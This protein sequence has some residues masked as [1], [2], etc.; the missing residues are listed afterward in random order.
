MSLRSRQEHYRV[1]A[2]FSNMFPSFSISFSPHRLSQTLIGHL[3]VLLDPLG[4]KSLRFRRS[5][6][7]QNCSMERRMLSWCRFF[8]ERRTGQRFASR[9]KGDLSLCEREVQSRSYWKRRV[10]IG[11]FELLLFH[12]TNSNFSWILSL[13]A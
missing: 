9:R 8:E 7:F 3:V 6:R 4:W 12:S 2:E 11:F 13:F 5:I 1:K 10:S